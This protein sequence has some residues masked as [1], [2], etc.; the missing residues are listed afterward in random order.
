M[1]AFFD[2]TQGGHYWTYHLDENIQCET[3]KGYYLYPTSFL[4]SF[5]QLQWDFDINDGHRI[6]DNQFNL[7]IAT[8]YHALARDQFRF[9]SSLSQL[10]IYNEI[11]YSPARWC[12]LRHKLGSKD[13][14]NK[15]ISNA[16]TIQ[17]SG[18]EAFMDCTLDADP[19]NIIITC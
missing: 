9:D 8:S 14:Y 3:C 1:N 12:T 17:V 5:A 16:S 13:I 7:K 11:S 18:Y 2:C 10:W 15:W 6:E 19:Q 4:P